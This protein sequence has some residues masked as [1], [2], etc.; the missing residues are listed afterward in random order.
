MLASNFLK[1]STPVRQPLLFLEPSDNSSLTAAQVEGFATLDAGKQG[2]EGWP[3]WCFL[4]TQH[5]TWQVH[6]FVEEGSIVELILY[7]HT[8][9]QG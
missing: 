4:K 5:L 6:E 8:D 2:S 1:I 7:H 3:F 9:F